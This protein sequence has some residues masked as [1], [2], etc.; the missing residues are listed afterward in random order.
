MDWAQKYADALALVSGQELAMT[1][2]D[3]A[4]VLHL[5]RLVAHGTERKNAPLA[6]FLAGMFVVSTSR[7]GA[8]VSDALQQ[9]VRVAEGLTTSR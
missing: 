3:A 5:A 4:A 9:A 7:T 1:E 8:S 6:A 2:G